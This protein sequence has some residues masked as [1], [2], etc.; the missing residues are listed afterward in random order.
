MRKVTCELVF[1]MPY[2]CPG[3]RASAAVATFGAGGAAAGTL[4]GGLAGTAACGLAEVAGGTAG[5]GS[6]VL[7]PAA[8]S[9]GDVGASSAWA[10]RRSGT[11]VKP[12]VAGRF[13]EVTK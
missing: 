6:G 11:G 10:V 2:F 7:G 8:A 3:G 1:W 12:G 4:G 9:G 5:G 13:A